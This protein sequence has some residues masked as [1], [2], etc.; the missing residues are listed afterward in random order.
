MRPRRR[1]EPPEHAHG[2]ERIPQARS[3]LPLVHREMHA[4][5]MGVLEGPAAIGI[6][7]GLDEVNRLRHSFVGSGTGGAHVVETSEHLVMPVG[8]VGELHELRVGYIP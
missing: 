6:A 2:P 1:C 4:T 7:L 5:G 8:G 3:A